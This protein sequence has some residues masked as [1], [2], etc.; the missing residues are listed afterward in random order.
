LRAWPTRPA[1]AR[2]CTGGEPASVF[3]SSSVGL[4][5]QLSG[6]CGRCWRQAS[7]FGEVPDGAFV[8]FTR[9]LFRIRRMLAPSTPTEGL[10]RGVRVTSLP[11]PDGARSMTT[12]N[13]LANGMTYDEVRARRLLD[14]VSQ[15]P[16]PVWGRDELAAAH[17][18]S[19]GGLDC[20]TSSRWLWPRRSGGLGGRR[21][22]E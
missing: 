10:G 19:V 11:W 18:R 4:A 8:V 1:G 13:S 14:L 12:R 20:V 15:V 21:R 3:P 22:L 5:R 9:W 7:E 6:R 16:T 2:S 17:V